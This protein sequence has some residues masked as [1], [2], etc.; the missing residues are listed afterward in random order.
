MSPEHVLT[1]KV[2]I[3]DTPSPTIPTIQ[4][5]TISD[6]E[7]QIQAETS[8][9]SA[10]DLIFSSAAEKIRQATGVEGCLFLDA[11][12]GV[13]GA[14]RS[15]AVEDSTA[16]L[17]SSSNSSDEDTASSVGSSSWPPARVLGFSTSEKGG[18][19]GSE[20]ITRHA[21]IAEKLLGTLMRRYPKG[22]LFAFDADDT[23]NP[24]DS[25]EED[26]LMAFPKLQDHMLQSH[27]AYARQGPR[28]KP[29]ARQNE[30][31]D[32]RRIF[33]GA[34]SVAFVP[35]WDPRKNRWY[36]GG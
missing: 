9:R 10:I 5:A 26:R 31:R 21:T 18:I 15:S 11:T 33:P 6:F 2:S 32:I 24:T 34:R 20:H 22:K 29:W 36:A 16:Q 30:G 3:P 25:S 4:P 23:L 12:P 28:S 7:I 13:F 1:G 8:R 35:V 19:D 17:I 27:G 14:L